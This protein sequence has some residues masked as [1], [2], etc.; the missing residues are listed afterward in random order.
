MTGSPNM[1]HTDIGP[2]SGNSTVKK[3]YLKQISEEM[4]N[5]YR[6]GNYQWSNVH[7]PL[8]VNSGSL[9]LNMG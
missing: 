3:K 2:T 8:I 7:E 5:A 1:H 6:A 4:L 9:K